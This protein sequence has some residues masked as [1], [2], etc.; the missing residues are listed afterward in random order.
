MTVLKFDAWTKVLLAVRDDISI[1]E[2]SKKT[3]ITYSH[4]HE[5]ILILRDERRLL[6]L[7]RHGRT[8][9]ISLTPK[10]VEVVGHLKEINRLMGWSL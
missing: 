1:S 6:V 4:V 10:G 9:F 3:D 7:E 2:I 8:H 5:L